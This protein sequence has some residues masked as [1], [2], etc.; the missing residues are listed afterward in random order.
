MISALRLFSSSTI[1]CERIAL[2]VWVVFLARL[3]LRRSALRTCGITLSTIRIVLSSRQVL[4]AASAVVVRL[5]MPR[6][7]LTIPALLSSGVT[8]PRTSR[9][10]CVS[11]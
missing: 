10:I 9:S 5:V 11:L 6:T 3:N 2:R 4:S 7:T 8:P 1:T